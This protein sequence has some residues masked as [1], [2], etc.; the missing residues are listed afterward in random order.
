MLEI[1]NSDVLQY[2]KCRRA[3][4]WSSPLRGNLAPR[5]FYEPFFLGTAVHYGLDQFYKYGTGP[6][7]SMA[8][9][10][11]EYVAR[12][13]DDAYRANA[14]NIAESVNLAIGILDHYIAWSRADASR[15]A[16]RNLDI[17][18][19]EQR[20]NVHIRTPKGRRIYSRVPGLGNLTLPVPLVGRIDMIVR[21]KYDGRL[22]LVEHKTCRSIREREAQ[23]P[24]EEQP[25][26]YANAATHLLS[27]PIAGIIY[28]LIRKKLPVVPQ[29]LKST[30]KLSKDKSID[31]TAEVYIAEARRLH[32]ADATRDFLRAEYGD[33]IQHLLDT[34]GDQFFKRVVIRRTAEELQRANV[35]LVETAREMLNPRTPIYPHGGYHCTW[36]LFREPCLA[37]NSG[38][39]DQVAHILATNYTPNNYADE[40]EEDL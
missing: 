15:Y 13:G 22:Y 29:A 33:M 23:L 26:N 40:R 21:A 32:G 31:T 35:M 18:A 38:D 1:H 2:K 9:S 12:V 7:T 27:E 6:V 16:D 34:K 28:N 14:A 19:G 25:N 37:R 39:E 4:N 17:I 3:W 5:A 24:Y 36:C 20:F 10:L 11:Q 8:D 30:G